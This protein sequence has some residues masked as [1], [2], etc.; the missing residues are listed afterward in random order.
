LGVD[1]GQGVQCPRLVD[2]LDVG[3]PAERQRRRGMAREFLGD[4]DVRSALY[5]AAVVSRG[6]GRLSNLEL[7]LCRLPFP[8]IAARK[9]FTPA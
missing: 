5:E 4:L 3:V 2:Q 8:T 7:P 9:D 6:A 1:G